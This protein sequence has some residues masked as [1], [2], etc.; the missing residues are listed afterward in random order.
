M[1]YLLSQ[2]GLEE[3]LKRGGLGMELTEGGSNLSSGEKQLLCI[4]RAILRKSKVVILDEATSS[5][6]VVTEQKI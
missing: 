3:I 5:I 2:A 1:V 4:V 6:D